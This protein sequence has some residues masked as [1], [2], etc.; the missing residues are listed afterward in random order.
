VRTVRTGPVVGLVAHLV[1]LV[2][3]S[4]AVDLGG[5]GWCAG[6]CCALVSTSWLNRA[7]SRH[8]SGRL[9][10]ASR[11]TLA[12]AVLV[13]G[14]SALIADSLDRP[15]AVAAVVTLGAA[16]LLLDGVDGKVARYTG[17][18]SRL[19]ASFDMEVDAFLILVLSV[20]VAR[21]AGA[22][23]L[24]IGLARYA[25]GVAGRLTP[26]M[27]LPLPFRYWRKVVTAVQGIAL[28]AAITAVLPGAVE[29]AVLLAALALLAESFGRDVWWQ[30]RRRPGAFG[31]PATPSVSYA[32][33]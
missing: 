27:S 22:W 20:E 3:L 19:G 15:L 10:P 21:T 24:L 2:G 11:V 23:V 25:F 28:T 5:V 26:W 16:A 33:P 32:V 18:V 29:V 13:G 17:T 31:V 6:I 7:M 12:R 9:G 1:L 30:W 8:N 14:V 4:R